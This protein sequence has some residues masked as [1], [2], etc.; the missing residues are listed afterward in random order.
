MNNSDLQKANEAKQTLNKFF[1]QF[2]NDI[3]TRVV[4]EELFKELLRNEP[5]SVSVSSK[6]QHARH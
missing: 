5:K 2:E 3:Y 6:Q 4:L 1:E